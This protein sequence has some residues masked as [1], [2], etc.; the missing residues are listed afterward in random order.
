MEHQLPDSSI[1][2]IEQQFEPLYEQLQA[3]DD[4]STDTIPVT[5]PSSLFEKVE[6]EKSQKDVI[7]SVEETKSVYKPKI[8]PSDQSSLHVID[9]ELRDFDMTLEIKGKAIAASIVVVK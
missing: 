7:I 2:E 5:V 6:E 3:A 8:Q 9:T 1:E 4:F